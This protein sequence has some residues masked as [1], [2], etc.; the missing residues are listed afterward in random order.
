VK[1]S[2]HSAGSV[3]AKPRGI[4]H[5]FWNPTDEPARV[6]ELIVPGGFERYFVELGEILGRGGP[7]DLAALGGLGSRYGL[8]S[9]SAADGRYRRA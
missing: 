9:A 2:R 3:V 4:P 8:P 7:P 5:A 1:R 6:L